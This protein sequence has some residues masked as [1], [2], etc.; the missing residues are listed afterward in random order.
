M[1][2]DYE[3]WGRVDGGGLAYQSMMVGVSLETA[4]S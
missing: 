3:G 4:L 2:S 1:A